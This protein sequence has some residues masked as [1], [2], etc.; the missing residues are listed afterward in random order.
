[1]WTQRTKNTL[2]GEENIYWT[3][4]QNGYIATG[5][6]EELAVENLGKVIL[7]NTFPAG[8]LLSI[9]DRQHFWCRKCIQPINAGPACP[10]EPPPEYVPVYRINIGMYSQV[11]DSCGAVVVQGV[12][13]GN[14]NPL[15]LFGKS[16]YPVVNSRPNR[17]R[18]KEEES[19]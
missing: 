10:L 8:Y 11:C 12:R 1:M 7:E 3:A 19:A 15:C 6:T 4:G 2:D 9:H 14:G 13:Q 16:T 18:K 5:K 17:N